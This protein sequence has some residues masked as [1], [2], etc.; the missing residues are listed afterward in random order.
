MKSISFLSIRLSK[1][2]E[3][4][5]LNNC[6][7]ILGYTRK[8]RACVRQIARL[9]LHVC[10]SRDSRASIS[11]PRENWHAMPEYVF[12]ESTNE[13]RFA[14]ETFRNTVQGLAFAKPVENF[15]DIHS[16]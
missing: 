10:E 15:V 9:Y 16:L 14:S 1:N 7:S 2:Y 6:A 11:R 12:G 4:G 3:I 13:L 8:V 5:F